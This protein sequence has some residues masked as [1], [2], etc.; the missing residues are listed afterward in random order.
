MKRIGHFIAGK[1][2]AG[3]GTRAGDI[4]NPATGEVAAQVAFATAGDVDRA[5]AAAR[6]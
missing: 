2:D 3:N 6:A 5:V 1:P 4:T